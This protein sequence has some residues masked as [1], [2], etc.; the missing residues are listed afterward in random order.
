MP[1]PF[2]Q[3]VQNPNTLFR[4]FIAVLSKARNRNGGIL[5]SRPLS[6]ISPTLSES[7]ESPIFIPGKAFS[8]IEEKKRNCI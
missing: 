3:Q 6:K 7:F 2:Q 4:S 8:K 5:S 1:H